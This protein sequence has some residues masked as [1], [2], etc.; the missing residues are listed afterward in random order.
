V[1]TGR[2]ASRFFFFIA[3]RLVIPR[4]AMMSLIAIS[5]LVPTRLKMLCKK[6]LG[7]ASGSP[8]S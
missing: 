1:I 4:I 8:K 5:V 2:G 6:R 3:W 7:D